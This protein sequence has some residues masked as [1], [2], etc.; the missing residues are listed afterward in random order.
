M[1][2]ITDYYLAG[3][4]GV[5]ECIILSGVP[6]VLSTLLTHMKG[7]RYEGHYSI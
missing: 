1:F 4:G 7:P 2:I 3:D 5:L 6:N